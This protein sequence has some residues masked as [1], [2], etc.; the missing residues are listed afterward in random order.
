MPSTGRESDVWLGV[1]IG[2]EFMATGIRENG[3]SSMSLSWKQP[4]KAIAWLAMKVDGICSRE[5]EHT[6]K[7]FQM[8]KLN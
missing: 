5:K 2:S 6:W 7:F 8:K 1:V 3:V 4:S